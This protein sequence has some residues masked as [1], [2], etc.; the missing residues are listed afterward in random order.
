VI[1]RLG[2]SIVT[3]P[4]IDCGSDVD[5]RQ[6]CPRCGAEFGCG[7]GNR[8]KPCAC[9]TLVLTAQR[10]AAIRESWT[11]CLCVACLAEL[12]ELDKRPVGAAEVQRGN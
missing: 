8:V 1:A 4:P 6:N 12:A 9:S 2:D 5:Q 3:L 10:L 7:A 11:A